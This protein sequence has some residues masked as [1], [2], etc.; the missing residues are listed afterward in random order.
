M[1]QFQCLVQEA[2]IAD[3]NRSEL[4]ARLTA[5]HT[6][7]YPGESSSFTWIPISS[8]YMFTEG[9]QSTSSIVACFLDHQTT[10]AG[11]ERYMRDVCDVWT[12]LTDCTDHE[13]VVTITETDSTNQER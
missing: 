11:R 1:S 9:A 3:T 7:H 5:L 4:E 10:L 2:S 12:E 8:G 13:V 6:D